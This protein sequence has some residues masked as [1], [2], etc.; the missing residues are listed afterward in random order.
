M[1]LPIVL[2]YLLFSSFLSSPLFFTL[3]YRTVQAVFIASVQLLEGLR[4][5]GS[6]LDLRPLIPYLGDPN[7]DVLPQIRYGSMI[8]I[9]IMIMHTSTHT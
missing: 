5:G 7:L 9:M 1:L 4:V 2:S 6:T 8:V 3:P